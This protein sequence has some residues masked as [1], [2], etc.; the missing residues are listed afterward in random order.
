LGNSKY[1]I[2]TSQTSDVR[3]AIF[4]IASENSL[5]LVGLKQEEISLESIFR[6]LTK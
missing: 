6:E 1:Q 4:K 3:S 5:P 2:N